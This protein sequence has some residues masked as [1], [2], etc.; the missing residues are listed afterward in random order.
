MR[1]ETIMYRL[2]L[3]EICNHFVLT[4]R[5]GSNRWYLKAR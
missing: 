3:G 4:Q 5:D 2:W 1:I